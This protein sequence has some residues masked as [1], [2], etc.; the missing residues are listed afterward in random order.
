MDSIVVFDPE[1]T[2]AS[3]FGKEYHG[4][5]HRIDIRNDDG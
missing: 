4:G 2:F 5:G 3:S 1:G